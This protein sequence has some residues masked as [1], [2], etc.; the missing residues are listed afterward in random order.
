MP[1]DF[2]RSERVEEQIHRLL[3]EL[4]LREVKDPRVGPVTIT[5]VELSKDL[6]HAKVYFVPFDARRPAA[7]V[8]RALGS[9]AGFLRVQLKK[10]L[11]MRQVPELRF[12]A[13]ETVDRAAR[14]SALISAAVASDT[15]RAAPA[16]EAEGGADGDPPPP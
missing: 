13:D 14:L 12:L 16:E 1:R 11:R 3:A 10:Q 2:H 4:L 8:A 7:E 9:A 15:A 5:A 6:S